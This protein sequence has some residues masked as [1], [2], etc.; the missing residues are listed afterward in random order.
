MNLPLL[1]ARRYL[2]AARRSAGRRMNAVNLITLISIAV[3]AV[4][5][6]AMVVVLST[7]NGITALVDS[8]YSPFDQDLTITPA[9]G[10]TLWRDSLDV[11]RCVRQRGRSA[12]AG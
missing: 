12:P 7:L 11:R 2:L 10:K 6:G 4:V 9:R 3:V 1:F 8:I 5:T